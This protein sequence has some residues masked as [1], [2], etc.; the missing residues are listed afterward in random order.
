MTDDERIPEVV[1]DFL[2]E[3]GP[4]DSPPTAARPCIWS[5]WLAWIVALA[6]A[7]ASQVVL[8]SALVGYLIA[9]GTPPD[10]IGKSL[11]EILLTPASFLLVIVI[12]PGS[13]GLVAR[14]SGN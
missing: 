4:R 9:T 12:G 14:H 1:T 6:A 3:T 13:F 5:V 11:G 8:V 2:A 7:V 10:I